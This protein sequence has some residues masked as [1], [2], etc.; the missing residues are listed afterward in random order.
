MNKYAEKR[1]TFATA[2]HIPSS[3]V[4]RSVNINEETVGENEI[5]RLVQVSG[6]RFSAI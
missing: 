1:S 5:N 3:L 2:N 6:R 4:Q